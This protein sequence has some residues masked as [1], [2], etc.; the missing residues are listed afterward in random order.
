MPI[1]V[2]LE[3]EVHKAILPQQME[4]ETALDLLENAVKKGV[5]N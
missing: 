4:M 5:K 2:R 1:G 3:I